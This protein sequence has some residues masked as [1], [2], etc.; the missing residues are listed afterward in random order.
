M[1]RRFVLKKEEPLP[2]QQELTIDYADALNPQQYAAVTEPGGPV[3]VVAGAGT[4]KTRT[5][6]YRVAYLVETGTAPN[7]IV[8]LTFTRR[9]AREMLARAT[10]LLDG[11]CQQVRGGTF[12][13]FCLNLLRRHAPKLGFDRQFTILDA[14]DAADVVD[15]LRTAKNL[16]K[17]EKRFPRKKTLYNM[18]SAATNRALP[19]EDV[20]EERYPQFY[21]YLDVLHDLRGDY[22]RYKK[23]HHLMDYDDL[24]K[25]SLELFEQDADVRRQVATRCRHVLVDEYQDTNQLQAGLVRAFASVHGNVMAVG[26][27]AQSIYRFRGADFRNIF[28]FPDQFPETKVLKLEQNYRSTQPILDLANHL[29][30][31]AERSYDKE[32]FTDAKPTGDRPAIIPAPDN[33]FESRFVTQMI[34]QLREQNVPLNRMA[35]L[36]R[37]G[38]NSYDLEVE[39][40]RRNIPFVK[41]GGL[42]LSEAAH[43]KDVLAHLKVL[44]NPMD[45]A[46]WNRILQLLKGIGPKTAHDLIEWI[47]SASEDPFVLQER[48]Y[49][50][51]Y[52]ESLKALFSTLRAARD[53]KLPLTS[54][55]EMIVEYYEPVCKDKYYEDYPKRLQDLDHFVGL[56]EAFT[57]RGEFLASLALDPIELSALEA[58][59]LEDDEPPLVLSTIHSAK[60]LEFHTVF[61]IHALEGVL[62]SGY[63]MNDRAELDEELRLLYV[64]VT[65]AE[66]NLFI[67]YPTVQYRRYQGDYLATPSRFIADVPEHL[68][69]PWQLVEEG[70]PRQLEAADQPDEDTASAPETAST[71]DDVANLPF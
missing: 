62:P 64:A 47:T 23:Q 4:G 36:F 3:L 17:G 30:Q 24:L 52:I 34:L 59:E 1:A 71:D 6:V 33:R 20:L 16:N 39:L 21:D 25:L 14:A 48:P 66:E 55:V 18:F 49:S 40:N 37:S 9:A 11:R 44:E 69:E 61:I 70:A 60:G 26:D 50:S 63:A 35:V 15:V 8:L 5:L 65:R 45:A 43:I 29:I 22:A 53:P 2:A 13:A 56:A 58:E 12:H 46:A 41:Y 31:E 28:Q 68:L 32:L 51:R 10:A 27:D 38:F 54:Q 42:K 7:E 67:S 57:D 19:L